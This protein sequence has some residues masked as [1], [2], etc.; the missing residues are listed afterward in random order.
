MGPQTHWIGSITR[1]EVPSGV[2][3]GAVSGA[4]YTRRKNVKH[5]SPRR[6]VA[7]VADL[8]TGSATPVRQRVEP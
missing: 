7:A 6:L 8:G 4:Y 1:G 2:D 3:F 5:R